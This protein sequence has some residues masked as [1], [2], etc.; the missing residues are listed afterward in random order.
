MFLYSRFIQIILPKYL[1]PIRQ[2]Y[3]LWSNK[4]LTLASL[5]IIVLSSCSFGLW[6]KIKQISITSEK[7]IGLY[8]L[9]GYAVSS[10]KALFI[11]SIFW[12]GLALLRSMV[13]ND[14]DRTDLARNLFFCSLPLIFHHFQILRNMLQK[15]SRL[16]Q[17]F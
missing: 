14:L 2:N 16:L 11:F 12:L 13:R 10:L 9:T 15:R 3:F 1:E 4:K 8:P 5:A 7:I 17:I 6:F